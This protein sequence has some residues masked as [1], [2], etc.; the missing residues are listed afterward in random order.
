VTVDLNTCG[1]DDVITDHGVYDKVTIHCSTRQ[2]LR[3]RLH[4]T[5]NPD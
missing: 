5:P 2:S 3:G 1:R 4:A